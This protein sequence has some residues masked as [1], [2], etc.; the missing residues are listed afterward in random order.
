MSAR[1]V[2][3]KKNIIDATA[4][5]STQTSESINIENYRGYAIQT[6]VT[7][8]TA[9]ITAKTFV[10]AGVNT[11]TNVITTATNAFITGL[12]VQFTTDGTLP[13]GLSLSTDY[14]I[15]KLTATTFKV[16]SSL[17]LALAGTAVDIIDTG[18]VAATHTATP[19]T[20]DLS[21]QVQGSL[22]N[23]SFFNIGSPTAI[24]TTSSSLINKPEEYYRFVRLV[25]TLTAG[26][27]TMVAHLSAKGH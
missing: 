5:T 11:T 16:A 22:D 8:D 21:A 7:D 1:F 3:Y 2:L 20:L 14:F 4:T 18:S 13:D 17:A 25:I 26:S 9:A 10:A 23:V 15:I 24:T 6:S 27:S 12:K 19:V